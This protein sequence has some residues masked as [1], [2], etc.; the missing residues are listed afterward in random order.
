MELS[1]PV[2]SIGTMYRIGSGI[3]FRHWLLVLCV[4]IFVVVPAGVVQE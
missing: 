3:V 2:L 1:Q 4:A